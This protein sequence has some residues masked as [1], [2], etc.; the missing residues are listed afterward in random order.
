VEQLNGDGLSLGSLRH[1]ADDAPP[2]FQECS[3]SPNPMGCNHQRGLGRAL[4]STL[5][6]WLN[7]LVDRIRQSSSSSGVPASSLLAVGGSSVNSV[8]NRSRSGVVCPLHSVWIFLLRL[9]KKCEHRT[10][11]SLRRLY[12]RKDSLRR[13]G[14]RPV[15]DPN[16]GPPA[17]TCR[18]TDHIP[19]PS[20]TVGRRKM[21][22]VSAS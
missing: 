16:H 15:P 22:L 5:G 3:S 18:L 6:P 21:H 11:L 8:R 14:A 9:D 19:Q 2:Q 13:F 17:K 10:H 4:R 20:T 12:P 1:R 7:G